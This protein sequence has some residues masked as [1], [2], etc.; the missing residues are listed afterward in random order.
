MSTPLRTQYL[1]LKQPFPDALLL[2]RLGDFYELYDADARTAA[3]ELGVTPNA[4]EFAEGERVT[5]CSLSYHAV[6]GAIKRLVARGYKVA[7]AEQIGDPRVTKGLI[8]R[9]VVRV[10]TPA[11]AV[12]THPCPS[13]KRGAGQSTNVPSG[14]GLPAS[15]REIGTSIIARGTK[16]GDATS[17]LAAGPCETGRAMTPAVQLALFD[18]SAGSTDTGR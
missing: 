6:K 3:R 1:R 10:V 13:S 5:L 14:D 16:A 2:F 7:I 4:R 17:A 18:L 9:E 15:N 11:S 8:E 12:E